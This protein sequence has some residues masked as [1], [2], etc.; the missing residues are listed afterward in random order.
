MWRMAQLLVGF[1]LVGAAPLAA[2][3]VKPEVSQNVSWHWVE[4]TKFKAG[5][6]QQASDLSRKHFD[7]VDNEIGTK[8]ISVHFAT[9]EWDRIEIFTMEGGASDLGLRVSPNQAKFMNE[10]ARR[11]GGMANAQKLLDEYD[12]LVDR[13]DTQ[14]A[15]M[16][17]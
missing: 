4:F 13:K 3:E 9:G 5:K 8:I 11:E 6:N 10:L 1:A 15:H 12:S 16:H 7:P 14:I 17:P 2:Q